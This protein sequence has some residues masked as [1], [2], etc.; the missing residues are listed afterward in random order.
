MKKDVKI[1]Y[2]NDENYREIM[3][4]TEDAIMER[5][6]TFVTENPYFFCAAVFDFDSGLLMYEIWD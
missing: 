1:I 4:D 6:T 5:V 2:N 3:T